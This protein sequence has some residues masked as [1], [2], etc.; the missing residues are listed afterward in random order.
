M[1]YTMLDGSKDFALELPY[2]VMIGVYLGLFAALLTGR[3]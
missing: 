3:L 2:A 1:R